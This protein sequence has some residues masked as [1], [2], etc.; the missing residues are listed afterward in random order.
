MNKKFA[1]NFLFL[2]NPKV[3]F[4][5]GRRGEARFGE[6]SHGRRSQD[7][8]GMV[9]R[10]RQGVLRLGEARPSEAGVDGSSRDRLGKAG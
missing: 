3:L 7:R 8:R 4:K 5:Q 1:V 2:A 6:V 9:E 10:G